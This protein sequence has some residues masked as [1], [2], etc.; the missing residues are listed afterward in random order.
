MSLAIILDIIRL[1][2]VEQA[3]DVFRG[4][5]GP[6]LGIG[7]TR[8]QVEMKAEKGVITG[9]GLFSRFVRPGWM[10]KETAQY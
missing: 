3:G 7:F 6:E 5:V 8:M 4:H 10:D 2:P 1:H 9:R